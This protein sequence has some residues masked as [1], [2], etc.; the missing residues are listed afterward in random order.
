M[1]IEYAFK[2]VSNDV[3]FS[4]SNVPCIFS[5]WKSFAKVLCSLSILML[6]LYLIAGEAVVLKMFTITDGKQK[7]IPV[8]GCRCVKGDLKKTSLYR[9]L[10]NNEEVF[11][12]K[13]NIVFSRS[14]SQLFKN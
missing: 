4:L 13:Y 10:R 11:R 1:P 5:V 8:A 2:L 7:N 14:L 12:G 3:E 6:I 9:V